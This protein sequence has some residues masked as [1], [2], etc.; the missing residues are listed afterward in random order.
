[1]KKI[2]F[3]VL[4]LLPLSLDAQLLYRVSKEGISTDSYILGTHHLTPYKFTEEIVGFDS[5]FESCD[6]VY[7]EIKLDKETT[8]SLNKKL[9]PLM[10]MPK[11]TLFSDLVTH[12]EYEYIDSELKRYLGDK[13]SLDKLA[14]FKPATISMQIEMML[15][16][17]DENGKLKLITHPID[18]EIQD[19]A[20]RKGK[21][22]FGL[23][24]ADSQVDLLFGDS[25]EEQADALLRTL[26]AGDMRQ[27][28][29]KLT[30]LY[31][32]QDSEGLYQYIMDSID[33]GSDDSEDAE[34]SLDEMLFSR[35]ENW[36]NT[37]PAVIEEGATFIAVGAGHLHGERGLIKLLEAKGFTISAVE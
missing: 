12:E 11:D 24:S 25:L 34:E 19:K 20:E 10:M 6:K 5:A 15:A 35:N 33:K 30:A 31:E 28:N 2:L 16:M 23:E 32:A 27:D 29:L 4:A 1:M 21:Q 36:A 9:M 17:Q 3:V 7:G 14:Q 22:I 18:A 37:L 8:K 26:R 13:F